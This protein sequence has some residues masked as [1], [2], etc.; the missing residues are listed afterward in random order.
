MR[1]LARDTEPQSPLLLCCSI[2]DQP[3]V[4]QS[5]VAVPAMWRVIVGGRSLKGTTSCRLLSLR[6]V[7]EYEFGPSVVGLITCCMGSAN[8]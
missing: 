6:Q 2:T 5:V 8:G 1:L 3:Y 7:S 4:P